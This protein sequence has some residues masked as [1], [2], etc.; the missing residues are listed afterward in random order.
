M[1]LHNN[2]FDEN[3]QIFLERK[4]KELEERLREEQGLNKEAEVDK[5]SSKKK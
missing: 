2:S 4:Y 3:Q 1:N 5:K